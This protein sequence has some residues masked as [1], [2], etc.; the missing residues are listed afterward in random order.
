P[1]VQAQALTVQKKSSSI[2]QFILFY[3]EGGKLDPVFVTNYVVI[4]V[5]DELSR[6]PGV[7]QASLFGALNYSMRIWFDTSRLT[8]LGLA[9]SDVIRAV[10]AQ[11]VQA[12]VGRIGS[13][14]VPKDQQFQLNVQTQG[15]LT[16]VE[17]FG[18][19]VIRS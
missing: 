3:G 4:N 12:P 6:T 19:I 11:N 8:S 7:G 10:Q 16:T 14:P 9:P 15:R 5:L 18:D 17:Q 13:R 2:L 1:E